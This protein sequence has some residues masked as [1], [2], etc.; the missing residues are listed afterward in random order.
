MRT[1][2]KR[3]SRAF[4]STSQGSVAPLSSTRDVS[5][6][7]STL[8]TTYCTLSCTWIRILLMGPSQSVH[9][10]QTNVSMLRAGMMTLLGIII[11][12]WAGAP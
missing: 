9:L 2:C 5:L 1:G 7:C 11:I 3:G 12:S 6:T 4:T 8:S 10:Q